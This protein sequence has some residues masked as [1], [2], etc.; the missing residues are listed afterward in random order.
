H[1]RG[2][3]LL[4]GHVGVREDE[5]LHDFLDFAPF[6]E[7]PAA[8]GEMAEGALLLYGV[9]LPAGSL[10]QLELDL[11]RLREAV[12]SVELV[13]E[14]VKGADERVAEIALVAQ[15]YRVTQQRE[16]LLVAPGVVE[17]KALGV[18]RVD[19]DAGEDKRLGDLERPLDPLR[20][21]LLLPEEETQSAER[22]GQLGELR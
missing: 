22:F 19:E 20:C 11:D 6:T 2:P 7:R 4:D 15:R 1:C 18:E 10:D 9:A 3:H 12:T 14:V 8:V 16:S 13:R 5:P 21:E 17:Q